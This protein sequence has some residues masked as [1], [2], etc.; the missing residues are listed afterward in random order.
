MKGF[1]LEVKALSI[2]VWL[3]R[4]AADSHPKR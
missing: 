1:D 2:S 4:I 3:M